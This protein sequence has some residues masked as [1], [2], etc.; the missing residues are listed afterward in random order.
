MTYRIRFR[1]F[2]SI[3]ST[4]TDPLL[5]IDELRGLGECKVI[6]QTEAIPDL[7]SLDPEA[8]YIYWDIILNTK[9]GLNAVKDVFIFVECDSELGIDVLAEKGP[10]SALAEQQ[11][12]R[13]KR[14]GVREAEAAS[15]VRVPSFKLDR[16]ADLIGELVTVQARLSRF[17]LLN[18]APELTAIAEG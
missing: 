10:S 6:A 1:P 17:S 3:M 8:C 14:N 4:G 11:C 16:L 12:T 13:E 18:G 5:L 7:E 15:S 2:L 9:E